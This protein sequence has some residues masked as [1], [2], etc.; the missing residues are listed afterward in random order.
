MSPP[1]PRCRPNQLHEAAAL[2]NE[3]MVLAQLAK[4]LHID[5]ATPSGCTAVLIAAGEGHL[6]VVKT[7][8]RKGADVFLPADGGGTPLHAAS[9]QGHLAIAIELLRA[10]PKVLNQ[11]DCNA[12]TPLH[13]A[14]DGG[15]WGVMR[16]LVEAGANINNRA[17]DGA[18]PLFSAAWQGNMECIKVLLQAKADPLLPRRHPTSGTP[19]V[20]LDAAALN[21]RLEAVRELV[22]QLGIKRCGGERGGVQALELAAEHNR[23]DIMSVLIDGGVVDTGMAL[24]IAAEFCREACV[25]FLLENHKRQSDVR[26][27]RYVNHRGKTGRTAL[28][29]A[30]AFRR[31]SP[32][33]V[34]LLIDAGAEAESAAQVLDTGGTLCSYTPLQLASGL[35]GEKME[36]GKAAT[37]ERGRRLQAIRHLLLRLEA[38]FAQSWLWP[39]NAAVSA[40]F[41]GEG[42]GEKKNM[43]SVPLMAMLPVLRR[44]ARRNDVAL[45]PLLF[46]W[47]AI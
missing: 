7:L 10:G 12:K 47:V 32:R 36:E 24:V 11:Q 26:A 5:Q 15:R 20:P 18:T 46:R 19:S 22:Q 35:L 25:K 30:I 43:P 28:F 23:V 42:G 14:A 34:R 4:G 3:R 37:E 1:P 6:R 16:M 17:K 33:I 41:A 8:L 2:G 27:L 44:R 38:V 29:N 21:G 45:G 40:H 31:P 9:Q 39:D 13:V